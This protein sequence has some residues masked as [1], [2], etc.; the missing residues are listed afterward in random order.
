MPP[1]ESAKPLDWLSIARLDF[2][3]TQRALRDHD[4][5]LAGFCLQQSVE[6]FL[7]ASV[8]SK[9]GRVRRTHDLEALLDEAVAHDS[10]LEYFRGGR[11]GIDRG[12]PRVD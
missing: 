7:K 3:R 11:E 6:K 1:E 5:G 2:D 4:P 8:V 9:G 12:H 10:S